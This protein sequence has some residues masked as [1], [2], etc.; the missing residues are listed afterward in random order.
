MSHSAALGST[1]Q[2]NHTPATDAAASRMLLCVLETKSGPQRS[3][4]GREQEAN[5][6]KGNLVS[7]SLHLH[8]SARVCRGHFFPARHIGVVI[9]GSGSLGMQQLHKIASMTATNMKQ[10]AHNETCLCATQHLTI[11]LEDCF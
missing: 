9:S 10:T 11:V 7:T 5:T 1:V 3:A 8:I 4:A 2:E 6:I